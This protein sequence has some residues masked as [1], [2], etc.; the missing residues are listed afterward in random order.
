MALRNRGVNENPIPKFFVSRLKFLRQGSN[1]SDES[2]RWRNYFGKSGG[3]NEGFGV[4][5]CVQGC[6]TDF[7]EFL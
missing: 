2:G 1:L 7:A 3:E 6:K 5:G 4:V